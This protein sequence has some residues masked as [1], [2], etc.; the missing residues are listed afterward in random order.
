LIEADGH[1]ED[2]EF[3]YRP[4]RSSWVAI[5]VLPAA[6]TNP[7]FVEVNGEPI[8]ASK[9]SAQWCLDA[10]D[11]CWRSKSPQIRENELEAAEIAY[12]HARAVYQ[13]I[14]EESYDDSATIRQAD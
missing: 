12:D 9:R 13:R 2:L 1:I 10:V 11:R 7:V 6:H 3:E 8:R 5:R 14:L 4:E